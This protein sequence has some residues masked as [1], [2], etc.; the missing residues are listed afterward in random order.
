MTTAISV[1]VVIIGAGPAGLRAARELAPHVAGEVLV[2]D[3]E[4]EPGGIPRHCDHLGYG[5]RDLGRFLNGPAYARRLSVAA[6][7]AGAHILTRAMVTGWVDERTVEVTSP[8]GR[9]A[10]TADAVVLATGARE[11]PRAARWIPGD[12]GGGVLTTGELQQMVHLEQLPVGTRAVVVGAELVSWSAALTL[13]KAGVETVALV[14]EYPR[15]D[16]YAVFGGPGR[17]FFRTRVMTSA[18]VVQVIGHDRVSAVVVE[19]L[20]SGA[21]ETIPCDTVV[22]TGDWIPDHELARSAGLPLDLGTLGPRVDTALRTERPGVFAAGNVLHPVDTADIA[23]LDGA[24]VARSVLAHLHGDAP[25]PIQVELVADAPFRWVAPSLMRPG[26]PPPPRERLLLWTDEFAASPR[27]VARQGGR[28]L[29]TMRVAWPA[30]PGRV[31]RAPWRLLR[32]VRS[33]G[34]DVHIGLV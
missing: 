15:P 22:F 20:G 11:R 18:K 12:R 30:A 33:D 5:M 19:H 31:F 10:I 13:R 2:L 1:P 3:R 21:R 23:A 9:Q 7:Q 6:E 24:H 4:A 29:N 26:D 14:T 34:G 17:L 28:V 16:A 27:V 25:P 8:N 32:D